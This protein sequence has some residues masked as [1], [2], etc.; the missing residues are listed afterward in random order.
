MCQDADWYSKVVRENSSFRRNTIG[1][2][3]FPSISPHFL[4]DSWFPGFNVVGTYLSC[5]LFHPPW[6]DKAEIHWQ[7]VMLRRLPPP[8]DPRS[9]SV[10]W[11]KRGLGCQTIDK[12]TCHFDSFL[13]SWCFAFEGTLFVSPSVDVCVCAC[14]WFTKGSVLYPHPSLALAKDGICLYS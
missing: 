7:N 4:R 5:I 10:S 6:Q 2:D 11:Q 8:L 3:R 12:E 13:D 1:L 14:E 9:C